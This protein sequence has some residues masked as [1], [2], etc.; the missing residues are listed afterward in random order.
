MKPTKTESG[1]AFVPFNKRITLDEWVF[2]YTGQ[3]VPGLTLRTYQIR[4]I[5]SKWLGYGALHAFSIDLSLDGAGRVAQTQEA[6]DIINS[7]TS[8][9]IVKITVAQMQEL[10]DCVQ[11]IIDDIN[12][13][14]TNFSNYLEIIKECDSECQQAND[15]S[16][17]ITQLIEA[18][19]KEKTNENS[20]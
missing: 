6:E 13:W 9:I 15:R 7:I 17:L 1:F 3:C 14:M 2:A 4:V 8:K 12:D 16:E 5:N 18:K 20:V 19:I 10:I 11:E